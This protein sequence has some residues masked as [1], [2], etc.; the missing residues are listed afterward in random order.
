MKSNAPKQLPENQIKEIIYQTLLGLSYQHKYGFFHHDI[1]PEN[2]SITEESVKIADFGLA[3]E[4]RSI[5]PYTEYVNARY[6]H[7]P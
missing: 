6:Y 1:K 3:R 5:P 7:A 4:I 2:L